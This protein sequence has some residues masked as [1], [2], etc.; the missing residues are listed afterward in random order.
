MLWEIAAVS[1][2][3]ASRDGLQELNVLMRD[4][5]VSKAIHYT[6]EY[7][8][9]AV[10]DQVLLNTTA[11]SLK[12]GTGGYH[13]VHAILPRN[14][15]EACWG[16]T[17]PALEQA[18]YEHLISGTKPID[19]D[20]GH[21]M[22]LRYT[23]LQRPMLA[24]EEPASPYHQV[25][26]NKQSLQGMA[27][28]IGELHSMLPA[29]VCRLLQ[30]SREYGITCRIAYVM[31]DGG[32]LPMA[33]SRHTAELRK[34]N[35]LVGTVTYGQAYGGDVEAVNK[36]TALLAAKHV[37]QAD[38]VIVTMGP[39]NVGTGTRLGFS[40]LETGELMNASVALGGFPWLIPRISFTDSRPRHHGISHHTLT[41]LQE[42]TATRCKVVLPNLPQEQ[43][44]YLR[45]QAEQALLVN[46]HEL[47]W[48]TPIST[49]LWEASMDSYSLPVLTMGRGL[50]DDPTYF[51][52]IGTAVEAAWDYWLETRN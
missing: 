44:A 22:K 32:A 40:G 11:I 23:S 5:S 13:I 36:Y 49:T 18:S 10:N 8:E 6:D 51:A 42:I 14:V 48:R 24:V 28:L 50:S 46:K 41:V 30:L 19:R 9:L 34:L 7:P 16:Y 4:G 27:V 37:L 38:I 35:W 1:Q 39:G 20:H 2:I 3:L 45:Q 17:L 47:E 52:G 33:F 43:G 12:L 15:E 31:S 29:A 21:I 25:Y 26:L